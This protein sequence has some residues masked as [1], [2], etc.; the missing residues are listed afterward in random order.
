M[1]LYTS[2]LPFNSCP[3]PVPRVA[4]VKSSLGTD[5]V[6]FKGL[7]H[8]YPIKKLQCICPLSLTRRK[9]EAVHLFCT[10]Q[11]KMQIIPPNFDPVILLVHNSRLRYSWL[12]SLPGRRRGLANPRGS[13]NVVLEDN[14]PFLLSGCFLLLIAKLTVSCSTFQRIPKALSIC[15]LSDLRS[16]SLI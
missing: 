3:T 10:K 13:Y 4:A 11:R 6:P 9:Y 12:I 8:A 1:T 16:K 7:T 2:N 5:T 15:K 14:T